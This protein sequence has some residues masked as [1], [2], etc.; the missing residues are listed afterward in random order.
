LF[1]IEEGGGLQ[2]RENRDCKGGR[3]EVGN[4]ND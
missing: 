1:S 4:C 2:S 3:V